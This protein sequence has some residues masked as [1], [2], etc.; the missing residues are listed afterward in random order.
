MIK[1]KKLRHYP[2]CRPIAL[3]KGGPFNGTRIRL[4]QGDTL[5]FKIQGWVGYYRNWKWMGINYEKP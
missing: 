1:Y 4:T 3:L 5:E 2:T